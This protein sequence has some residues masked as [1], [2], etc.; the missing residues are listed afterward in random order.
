MLYRNIFIAIQIIFNRMEDFPFKDDDFVL[1]KETFQNKKMIP[2]VFLCLALASFFNALMHLPFFL[3]W[4]YNTTGPL[5]LA[6]LFLFLALHFWN[7][8]ELDFKSPNTLLIFFLILLNCYFSYMAISY[9]GSL[10]AFAL[11]VTN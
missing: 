1:K 3:F 10:I 4:P 8:Y 6:I 7:W 2:I 5:C 11:L 9:V